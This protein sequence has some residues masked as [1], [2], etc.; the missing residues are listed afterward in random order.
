MENQA[1]TAPEPI[2]A[3][4]GY[5]QK[6]HYI[7]F[8][9]MQPSWAD[10]PFVSAYSCGVENR[11]NVHGTFECPDLTIADVD[12]KKCLARIEWLRENGRLE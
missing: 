5:G 11:W 7:T 10:K 2:V 8:S 4:F 3:Q 12:C 9:M 1:L 6:I